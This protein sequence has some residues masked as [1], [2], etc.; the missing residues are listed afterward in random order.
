MV[1]VT[2]LFI[3]PVKSCRAIP[4]QEAEVGERGLLH[5]REFLVV[6]DTDRFLTQRDAPELATVEL[7]LEAAGL[8]MKTARAGELSL[9][10]NN[11]ARGRRNVRIFSDDVIADDTGD[12]AAEWFS[13]ALGRTCRLVGIGPCSKRE[14]ALERVAEVHRAATAPQISFT[15]AFPTLLTSES[16]LVDLNT[17]LPRPI[18]MNRF[19]PNIVVRGS[20]PYEEHTWSRVRAGDMVFGCPAACLRCVISTTDQQ[21]G[22]RDGAEPLRTLAT[23][24]R[25]SDGGGVMFGQYLVH[26]GSGK[27][28]LGDVVTTER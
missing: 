26:S 14:V 21:T 6:D 3:Y 22:D 13:A 20:A 11:E 18:P 15:D 1:E 2:G 10:F 7:E 12:E 9:P 8:R 25:S 27:L 28:R 16:S 19:R 4:L 5:D 23:Y 17:R 24:R